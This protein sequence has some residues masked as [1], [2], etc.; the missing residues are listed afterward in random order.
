[1]LNI[2]FA[3][4][5]YLSLF[6]LLLIS[7]IFGYQIGKHHLVAEKAEGKLGIVKVAEGTVFALLG[8][9]IAF[10]FSGS[11]ERFEAHKSLIINEANAID[12]AY[13]EIDLLAPE[14]QTDLRNSFRAYVDS[15][16]RIYEDMP[17]ISTVAQDMQHSSQL[18]SQIWHQALKACAVTN[19]QSTTQLVIP[20]INNMFEIAAT[21]IAITKIHAPLAIF[22]LLIGLASLA[23]FLTGYSMA[24]KKFYL[25]IYI[26]SYIVITTLTIYIIIDMEFPRLGL[27]KVNMFDQVL[28]NVKDNMN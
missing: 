19:L 25:S 11:Y 27:I 6:L 22:I 14:T 20:A 23:S 2:L 26:I 10:T 12:T 4:C 13:L 7:V 8:L 5:V 1:M 15:R 24:R 16:I 18:R 9:L 28:V 21:R 17:D 3:L